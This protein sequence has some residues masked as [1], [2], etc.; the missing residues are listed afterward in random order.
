MC[1]CI[2]ILVLPVYVLSLQQPSEA[3]LLDGTGLYAASK[4]A[5]LALQVLVFSRYRS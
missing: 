1:V 2:Y 3:L 5:V 4:E